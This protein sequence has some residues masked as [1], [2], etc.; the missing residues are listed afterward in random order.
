MRACVGEKN[1]GGEPRGLATLRKQTSLM[2]RGSNM[3]VLQLCC[4]DLED[5][6]TIG[7]QAG[8]NVE[9][10]TGEGGGEPLGLV[11]LS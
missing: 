4:F 11:T 7:G 10:T 5:K 6:K 1:T 8:E 2:S 3:I 9:A